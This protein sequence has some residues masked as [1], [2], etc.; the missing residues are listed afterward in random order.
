M[1][2]LITWGTKRGGTESI[3]KIIAEEL[4]REGYAV[5]LIA[6]RDVVAPATYAAVVIGGALYSNRWHRDARRFITRNVN[7][8]R[9]VPVYCFSSGPLDHSADEHDIPPCPELAVLMERIGACGHV[10][11]GGRL[12]PLARGFPASAMAKS[13]SGDFHNE[14]RIR[15]WAMKLAR[16]LPT[17]R[18]STPV[19][20]AARS[21][22]RLGAHAWAGWGVCL[23]F[24]IAL[25]PLHAT[26]LAAAVY[27]VA[28]AC[29]FA[30][31]AGLYFNARGARP[32]VQA[33]WTFS[34]VYGAF[35]VLIAWLLDDNLER[36][37]SLSQLWLPLT[38]V[39]LVT[40]AVG[41]IMAM[42]P[43]SPATGRS[44]KRTI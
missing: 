41:E 22:T 21:L 20:P 26:P 3:A 27:V 7:A 1:R 13:H 16:S 31:I 30:G 35:D 25:W 11:F 24:R 40:W 8:L 9:R 19:E 42:F 10:T 32:P 28:P 29:V 4:E 34:A 33:A 12:S 5:D 17:A 43:A 38:F 44:R 23:L 36:L 6:A 18:P 14:E 15:A 37:T 2:V 39:F